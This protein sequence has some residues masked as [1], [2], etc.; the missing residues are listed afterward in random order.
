MPQSPHSNPLGKGGKPHGKK[1]QS[2]G[3]TKNS[4]TVH[5]WVPPSSKF[6]SKILLF[7]SSFLVK[8]QRIMQISHI[9]PTVPTNYT[10]FA[11]Q[12]IHISSM[13]SDSRP[14]AE[15]STKLE[16]IV[17]ISRISPTVP[18]NYAKFTES[19]P[20]ASKHK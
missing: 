20:M 16:R 5:S 6:M 17:Q 4:L 12:F 18:V 8:S 3:Q 14:S 10:K 9:S 19:T 11:T 7:K 13:L 2:I 1:S 15:N